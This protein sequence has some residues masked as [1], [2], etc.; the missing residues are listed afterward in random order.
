MRG[1]SVVADSIRF[2]RS[3]STQGLRTDKMPI[4]HKS[5]RKLFFR[6]TYAVLF[7]WA[8]RWLTA[9]QVPEPVDIA[10]LPGAPQ[11]QVAPST[12]DAQQITPR[13][14]CPPTP[15]P[16]GEPQ[17]NASA[18]CALRFDFF[19]PLG[20]PPGTGTLTRRDKLRLAA[21]DIADPFN[22]I[23]I[24]ATAAITIGSNPNTDYGPGMKGGEEFRHPADRGFDGRVPRYLSRSLAHEAGSALSSDPEC[25]NSPTHHKRNRAAGLDPKRQGKPYAQLWTSDWC[26]GYYR[27]CECLRA[28][29]QAGRRA[30]SGEFCNRNC[31]IAD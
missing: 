21:S 6:L 23:T 18:G 8:A 27:A 11:S 12:K 28:R 20:R 19:H 7:M 9:Q 5:R 24:G 1:V 2:A 3:E 22:L 17:K 16:A 15:P 29:S 4:S 30:N 26:S 14:N 13:K 10:V 25:L 31:F